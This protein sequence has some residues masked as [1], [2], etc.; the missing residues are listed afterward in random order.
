M[1]QAGARE[2]EENQLGFVWLE[3][4]GS[5]DPK[6]YWIEH[7]TIFVEDHHHR[8]M[9]QYKQLLLEVFL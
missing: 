8:D 6:W 2:M 9:D 3:G 4:Y 7:S 5:F 1:H